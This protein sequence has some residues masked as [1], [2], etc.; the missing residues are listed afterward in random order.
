MTLC[1]FSRVLSV[2][3]GLAGTLL[4]ASCA[5]RGGMAAA[6]V[7]KPD[8][9]AAVVPAV[10]SAGFYI[11]QQDGLFAA[12]GLHVKIV[13]AISSETVITGQLQGK[14]D[15]TQG[16]YV[17]YIQAEVEQHAR[18]RILCESSVMQPRTQG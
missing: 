4:T 2:A 16:N 9:V 6:G 13:P 12:E 1:R 17:S 11:A 8:L 18:L 15:V 10:D 5:S 7:E 3:A 14:Y